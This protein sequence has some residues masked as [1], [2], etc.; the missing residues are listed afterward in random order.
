[1]E[2]AQVL[3]LARGHLGALG[4]T[5]KRWDLKLWENTE[6]QETSWENHGE[7]HPKKEEKDIGTSHG[8]YKIW[9]TSSLRKSHG[10]PPKNMEVFFGKEHRR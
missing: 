7:N 4:R 1:M 9:E 10:N 5:A 8:N 2:P 3:A 6:N